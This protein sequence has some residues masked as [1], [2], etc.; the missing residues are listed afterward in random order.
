MTENITFPQNTYV[1]SSNTRLYSS[2]MRTARS[3]TVSPSMLCSVGGAWSGV[4]VP[5]P[6]RGVPGPGRGVPGPGGYPSMH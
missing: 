1:G 3:L 4:C 2:R 5:G 6:G